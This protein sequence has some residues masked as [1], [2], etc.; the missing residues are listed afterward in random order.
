MKLVSLP[1]LPLISEKDLPLARIRSL[2]K[3]VAKDRSAKATTE[4]E[5]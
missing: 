4:E 1:L 3:R 5:R 2:G